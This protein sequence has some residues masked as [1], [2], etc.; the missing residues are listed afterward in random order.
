MKIYVLLIIEAHEGTYGDYYTDA[1]YSVLN[2]SQFDE[3]L[4]TYKYENGFLVLDGKKE[5]KVVTYDK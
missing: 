1:F 5:Y 4:K 2:Q 3:Y